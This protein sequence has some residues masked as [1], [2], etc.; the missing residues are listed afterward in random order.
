VLVL[1][2]GEVIPLERASK[3]V[4]ADQILDQ[5]LRLRLALHAASGS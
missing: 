3:R 4:I 1:A 5:A 2:T